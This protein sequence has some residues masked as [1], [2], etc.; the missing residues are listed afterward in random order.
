MNDVTNLVFLAELVEH[1]LVAL[2]LLFVLLL[3]LGHA[4]VVVGVRLLVARVKCH[5]LQQP[6][7]VTKELEHVQIGNLSAPIKT[8][9]IDCVQTFK[10]DLMPTLHYAVAK[11]FSFH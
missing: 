8:A 4:L 7:R 2:H 11:R 9:N 1:A 5:R 3:Q 10:V 6:I